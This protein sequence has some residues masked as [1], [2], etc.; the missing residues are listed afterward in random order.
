MDVI[1]Y[2]YNLV[3]VFFGTAIPTSFFNFIQLFFILVLSRDGPD[4]PHTVVIRVLAAATI[5]ISLAGVQLLIEGG[6][7]GSKF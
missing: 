7:F 1:R 4:M 5:N 3:C 6:F 2:P